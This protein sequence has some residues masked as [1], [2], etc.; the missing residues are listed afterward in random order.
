MFPCSPLRDMRSDA[1]DPIT[2]A[3]VAALAAGLTEVG[4]NTIVDAY[5]RVASNS[6]IELLV[7]WKAVQH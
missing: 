1:M 3:I 2:A 4:K 6:F 7:E 5:T